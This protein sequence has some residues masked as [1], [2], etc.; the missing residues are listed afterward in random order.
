MHE[1]RTN[2]AVETVG[3]TA[4]APTKDERVTKA[5]GKAMK[6][7]DLPTPPPG[8][9]SGWGP[10]GGGGGLPGGGG[11]PP[12]GGGGSPGGAAPAAGGAGQPVAPNQDVRPHTSPLATFHVNSASAGTFL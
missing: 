11:G 10:P 12:G 8:G 5:F 4:A 6:K 9:P 1:M 3:F 7:Y 2:T